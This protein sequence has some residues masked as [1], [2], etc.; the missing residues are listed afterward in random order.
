MEAAG[1]YA[2]WAAPTPFEETLPPGVSPPGGASAR[3]TAVAASWSHVCALT[4]EG[5]AICGQDLRWQWLEGVLSVMS[6]PDPAPSR[7]VA[8]G[9]GYRHA[10]ALTEAGEAVCWEAAD[11]K[12]APPDPPP[13]RYVAVSDGPY[14][15]CALTEAGEA[16]CWGWNNFGQADVPAGPLHRDQRGRIPHLRHRRVGRVDVL[17][18]G[19]TQRTTHRADASPRSARATPRR[20]R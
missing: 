3:Y 18:R 20:A 2:K 5:R 16:A 7:Y 10:C 15:T 4:T 9:V 14:H 11:N 13:G 17:G 1:C 12:L 8:I 6:P 19:L